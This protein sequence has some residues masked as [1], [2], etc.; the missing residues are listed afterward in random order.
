M[1]QGD[2]ALMSQGEV[3]GFIAP[4]L[5]LGGLQGGGSA[6][7]ETVTRGGSTTGKPPISQTLTIDRFGDEKTHP[8]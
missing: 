5:R 4:F 3:S 8:P 7:V 6:T 2:V 1:W